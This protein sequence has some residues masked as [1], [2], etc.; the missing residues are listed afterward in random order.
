MYCPNVRDDTCGKPGCGVTNMTTLCCR[1]RMPVDDRH[2]TNTTALLVMDKKYLTLQHVYIDASNG[3]A[4]RFTDA[5]AFYL[6]THY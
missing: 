6:A 5:N 3:K 1:E 4:N 2:C